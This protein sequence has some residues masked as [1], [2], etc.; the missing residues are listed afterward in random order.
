M[1]RSEHYKGRTVADTPCAPCHIPSVDLI[2]VQLW[3]T[4]L[5]MLPASYLKPA[6]WCVCFFNSGLSLKPEK[7]AKPAPM[8]FGCAGKCIPRGH[9]ET[10][11]TGVG[12]ECP[13]FF[14]SKG[15]F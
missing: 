6:K 12:G 8:Q 1:S 13:S 14:P 10:P 15:E 2:S 5:G 9:S 3:W 11:G 4:I 7:T